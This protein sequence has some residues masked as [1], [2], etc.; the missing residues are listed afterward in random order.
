M[1]SSVSALIASF[2]PHIDPSRARAMSKYMRDQ[3]P[4]L[5]LSSPLRR[6]LQL[7]WIKEASKSPTWDHDLV[8]SLWALPE[9]EYQNAAVDLLVKNKKKVLLEDIPLLHHIIETKSWWDSVDMISTH[10]L[11]A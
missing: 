9:R 11:G 1:N 7:E 3:F 5:G 6:E 8:K 10:L 4:F 2:S